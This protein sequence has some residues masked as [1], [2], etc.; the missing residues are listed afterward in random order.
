MDD[1]SATY[2]LSYYPDHNKWNGEFR[3]ITV[4]VDRHD[5]EVHARNGYYAIADTATAAQLAAQRLADAVSSPLDA[6]DISFDVQADAID[7]SGAR[8]LKLKISFDPKQFHFQQQADRWADN[9]TS[10]F[11][12]NLTT[13]ARKIDT[14]SQTLNLKPGSADTI[15]N[16]YRNRSAIRKR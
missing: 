13:K 11:G 6:T 14:H 8:Q 12:C 1:Y 3:E 2:L 15:S 16:F 10:R 5:I 7:T 9:M 4:K